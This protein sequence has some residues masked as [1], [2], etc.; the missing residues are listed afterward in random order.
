MATG[1]GNVTY[2]DRNNKYQ[3]A[4]VINLAGRVVYTDSPTREGGGAYTCE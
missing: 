1:N 4:L 2:C 3:A